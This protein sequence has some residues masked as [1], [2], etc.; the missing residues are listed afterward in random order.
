MR[1][2]LIVRVSTIIAVTFLIAT[3]AAAQQM[4]LGDISREIKKNKP[5]EPTTRVI[6]NDDLGVLTTSRTTDAEPNTTNDNSGADK[7][8]PEE[9]K[10]S[11]DD[12]AKLDKEWSDKF[13]SQKDQI[14]LMEREL[15]V[16]QREN[17][18]RA[19]TFYA[20]AG[21]RLRDSAKYA[22]DDRKYRDQVDAKQKEIDAAKSKL[23]QMR[24]EARKAGVSPGSI[25]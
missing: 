14:A 16:L 3:A 5:A 25:G 2:Y 24:D 10:S 8:K 1:H 7:T 21:S 19:T 4:S 9:K 20:D 18:I 23:E 13:A 11:A 22:E 15:Q 17:K 12:Q 6:T